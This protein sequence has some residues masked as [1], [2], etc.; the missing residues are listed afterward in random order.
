MVASDREKTRSAS[1]NH[2]VGD[3][4]DQRRKYPSAA[5]GAERKRGIQSPIARV[6]S[7]REISVV[8]PLLGRLK[9]VVRRKNSIDPASNEFTV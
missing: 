1:R 7:S 8:I 5:S 2:L 3:R 4:E 6:N 9:F